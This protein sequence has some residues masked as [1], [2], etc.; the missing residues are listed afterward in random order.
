MRFPIFLF[1]IST[2]STQ[3]KNTL[4]RGNLKQGNENLNADDEQ[5]SR[6]S[7]PSSQLKSSESS[8]SSS[9]AASY[10]RLKILDEFR[11]K[12]PTK[13][14]WGEQQQEAKQKRFKCFLSGV[15]DYYYATAGISSHHEDYD[16]DDRYDHIFYICKRNKKGEGCLPLKKRTS[17]DTPT[18]MVQ[19]YSPTVFPAFVMPATEPPT[20]V[21]P[22]SDPTAPPTS[23]A[24]TDS[25]TAPPSPFPT[26]SPTPK[27]TVDPLKGG[28]S[29][30][31]ISFTDTISSHICQRGTV[32]KEVS[33]QL[34]EK[35]TV[36]NVDLFF[37]FDDTGNF[38]S[39]AP[40]M[41]EI[42][43]DILLELQATLPTAS[44]G[45]GIGRFEDYGGPGASFSN[46][47]V[48]GRPYLLNQPIVTAKTAGSLLELEA[49]L[50][51]ALVRTAS[52]FGGDGPEA[53]IA[54]GLWQVATGLG[55]DGNG[56]GC[57]TGD[58]AL[59]VAGALSTQVL[60]DASGDVPAFNT[61]DSNVLSSGT[62]GGAGF[63]ADALKLVILATD[64]CPV[65]AFDSSKE[66][67]I[68]EKIISPYTSGDTK[69]LSCSDILGVHRYGFVSDALSVENNTVMDAIVPRGAGTVP[70]TIHALTDAGIRVIGLVPTGGPL[71]PGIGPSIVS[72]TFL[73]TV[74]RL[75]GAVDSNGTA[76]VIPINGGGEDLKTAIVDTVLKAV[77]RPIDIQLSVSGSVPD[78]LNVAIPSQIVAD[79]GPGETAF[80]NVSFTGEDDTISGSFDLVF[81]DAKSGLQLKSIPV[82]IGCAPAA[83]FTEAALDLASEQP[84]VSDLTCSDD[85]SLPHR[86]ICHK[87]SRYN[88]LQSLCLPELGLA[89]YF[90]RYPES[91][92]GCCGNAEL[93]AP[94]F[95]HAYISR[96]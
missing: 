80:F 59:Q 61:L 6:D 83:D 32:E 3:S 4:L 41:T 84:C 68:P 37:L 45:Y 22:T 51:A 34:P 85:T 91:S 15:D 65:A 70:K 81:S 26:V 73:S 94:R 54:E 44:F 82:E 23:Q 12:I 14:S 24:P 53:A 63:R 5:H 9:A 36:N 16:N 21:A 35:S 79:V 66:Q 52:G 8:S 76:Q 88:I 87:E 90:E 19:S 62:K 92:C 64:V 58:S 86:I 78:G 29:P 28:V 75:T 95:C 31:S 11:H 30:A 77:E 27:P 1:L 40:N 46:E 42:F 96:I 48:Q 39:L 57:T 18:K 43:P 71:P 2:I 20:S 49:L 89:S 72:N 55:F 74:A 69:D 7:S 33:I 47:L 13:R 50:S 17:T 67:P 60:P 56:D 93:R 25:P 38:G 10:K